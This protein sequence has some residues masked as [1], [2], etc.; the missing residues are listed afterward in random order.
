[1]IIEPQL[2]CGIKSV[3]PQTTTDAENSSCPKGLVIFLHMH[4][5]GTATGATLDPV[6]P[7]DTSACC[8]KPGIEPPI[9]EISAAPPDPYH[10]DRGTWCDHPE[11]H[12]PV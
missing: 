11:S 8:Q 12:C 10:Q 2:T 9:S 5:D 7:K 1:M 6:F 3:S 4:T